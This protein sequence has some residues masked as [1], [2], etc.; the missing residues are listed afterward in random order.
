MA[1][2]RSGRPAAERREELVALYRRLQHH[3]CPLA[4]HRTNLVFGA[5]N[6]D[7]D[8]MF[9]GEAPGYNEDQQ[10]LPFVGAAG[11]LLTELLQGIGLSREDVWINN[12][13]MCRPP[14]NRDPL[15]EEIEECEPHLMRRIQ[16]IEPRII[17]T[18]GNYSTKLLTGS[19]VGITRVRG[20]PQSHV[21]A[22][23][24]VTVFPLLHPAA[25]LRTRSL[26][27]TMEADFRRLAELLAGPSEPAA[28]PSSNPPEPR[29]A[30][31]QLDLFG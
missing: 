6:A 26:M 18:L 25:V 3:E 23:L 1:D 27:E 13:L 9:V 15:P 19:K 11:Q 5:G 21:I 24:L 7:A 28:P 12:A 30:A 20:V 4:A 17:A 31:P 29:A 8:L 14:G 16:L 22:G 2:P 10:G